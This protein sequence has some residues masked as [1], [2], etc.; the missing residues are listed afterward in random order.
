MAQIT[1]KGNPFQTVGD[2]PAVGSKAPDFTLTNT[3]LNDVS[4]GEWLGKKKLL[5]IVPSVDT[6]VCAV[7]T[8][9]RFFRVSS[10]TPNNRAESAF[11]HVLMGA[12][13]VGR[14]TTSIG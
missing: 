2:L 10:S 1:L 3:D 11:S 12:E 13:P 7:S 6:P 5:S 4:L 14:I 8:K 9:A